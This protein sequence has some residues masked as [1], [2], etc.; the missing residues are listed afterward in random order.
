VPTN[1]IVADLRSN[2]ERY[3]LSGIVHIMEGFTTDPP[4]DAA[5]DCILAGRKIGLLFLDA[6]G[7]VERDFDLYRARLSRGSILVYDDYF[8]EHA[9]EKQTPIKTWVDQAVASGVVENLGLYRWGTWVG[10]YWG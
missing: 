4:I 6:D 2:V 7:N 10:R 3:G 5:V 9:P 1:D 8:S